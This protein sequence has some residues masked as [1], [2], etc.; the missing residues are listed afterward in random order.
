MHRN[1]SGFTLVEIMIVVMI[2]ALLSAIAIPNLLRA[3]VTANDASA[4]AALKTLSTAMETFGAT[5]DFYPGTTTALISSNPPYLQI[6]YFD[7]NTHDG[8]TFSHRLCSGLSALFYW[9]GS[10]EYH[11]LFPPLLYIK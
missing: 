1:R 10:D 7:G 2:I 6:D 9:L 11:Y 4:Q 5:N 3:R 8:F